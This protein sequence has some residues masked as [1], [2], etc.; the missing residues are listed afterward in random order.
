MLIL[1]KMEMVDDHGNRHT[2]EHNDPNSVLIEP[3]KSAEIV[4][5]FPHGGSLEF[6]CN[7]PGH[8]DSGMVGPRGDE[9]PGGYDTTQVAWSAA[10]FARGSARAR[11][12]RPGPCRRP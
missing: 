5:N 11:A 2:M 3:G 10:A 6:A 9:T 12:R 1:M 4:W 7:I 8:Y